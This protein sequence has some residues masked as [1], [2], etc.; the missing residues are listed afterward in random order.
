M[1][2]G[3]FSSRSGRWL[4]LGILWVA[5]AAL[6]LLCVRIVVYLAGRPPAL[7]PILQAPGLATLVLLSYL[8]SHGFRALRIT[9]IVGDFRI[10]LREMTAFHFVTAACSIAL[11]FKLGELLRISELPRMIRGS[12][13][14]AVVIVWVE[15]LFDVAVFVLLLFVA[16]LSADAVGSN[17]TAVML[18]SCVFI[19]LSLIA[20]FLLPDN[21]RRAAVYIIRRYRTRSTVP[22]LRAIDGTRSAIAEAPAMLRGK[23]SSL[24]VL[25]LLVWAL[26]LMSFSLALRMVGSP[27]DA[28]SSLLSFISS[29]TSGNTL[30]GMLSRGSTD[31]TTYLT[32]TQIPLVALGA[33]AGVYHLARGRRAAVVTA[34]SL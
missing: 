17:V 14:R 7:D 2:T 9:L 24:C 33:L 22:V 34:G 21:L 28:V 31:L 23:V 3:L 8:L 11:P 19:F 15:R 10:G 5:L 20:L 1:T 18:L 26:E 32:L 27:G 12:L 25:T 30:A 13:I 16:A 6:A 4:R 29:I